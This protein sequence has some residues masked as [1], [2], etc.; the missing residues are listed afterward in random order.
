MRVLVFCALILVVVL[1]FFFYKRKNKQKFYP[2]IDAIRSSEG[3]YRD[4]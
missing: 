1:S 4:Q 2:D 3:W